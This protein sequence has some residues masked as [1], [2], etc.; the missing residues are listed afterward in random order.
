MVLID[1]E[2][3]FI[4]S[5]TNSKELL[6]FQEMKEKEMGGIDVCKALEDLRLEGYEEGI[7]QGIK[8]VV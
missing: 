2:N 4:A 5:I 8:Q 7:E 3:N 1:K 6:K